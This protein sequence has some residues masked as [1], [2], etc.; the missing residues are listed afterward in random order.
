MRV[1]ISGESARR[2]VALLAVVVETATR[3][4]TVINV[5]VFV[6][7]VSSDR[8]ESAPTLVL[9]PPPPPPPV[10]DR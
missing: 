2:V 4:P 1:L 7:A 5:V 3:F 9:P 8:G 10:G 6:V